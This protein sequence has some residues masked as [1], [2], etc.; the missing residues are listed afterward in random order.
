MGIFIVEE[1]YRTGEIRPKDDKDLGLTQP[2]NRCLPMIKPGR[3]KRMHSIFYCSCPN[4]LLVSQ[5]TP[6]NL[7]H[8]LVF[9]VMSILGVYF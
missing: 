8:C 5:S 1:M 3:S 6:P 4:C 2:I 9:W 7:Q